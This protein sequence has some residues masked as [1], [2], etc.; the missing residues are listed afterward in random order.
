MPKLTE[1]LIIAAIAYAVVFITKKAP[2]LVP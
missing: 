2:Q 1:I